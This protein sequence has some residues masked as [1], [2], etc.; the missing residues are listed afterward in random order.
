[1]LFLAVIE[2][3]KVAAEILTDIAMSYAN[4][5]SCMIEELQFPKEEDINIVFAGSVF[6]KSE[7]PLLLDAIREKVNR[8]WPGFRT[9]YTLLD[10]PPVAGAVIWALNM[11]YEKGVYYDKVCAQ[12][13]RE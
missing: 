10:V 12:L 4:G 2:N 9:R 11:L 5:I 8:D 13:R 1:M 7:H 3:D 6:V